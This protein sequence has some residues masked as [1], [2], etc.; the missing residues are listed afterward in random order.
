MQKCVT[1]QSNVLNQDSTSFTVVILDPIESGHID[2]LSDC[3]LCYD[4]NESPPRA[5]AGDRELVEA[6]LSHPYLGDGRVYYYYY[7]PPR[8]T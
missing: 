8:R 6:L 3:M 1:S 4:A 2:T 7:H 5:G